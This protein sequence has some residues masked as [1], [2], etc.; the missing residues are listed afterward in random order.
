MADNPEPIEVSIIAKVQ[1]LLDGLGQ[2]TA[3]VKSATSEMTGSLKG[4]EQMVTNLKAP[5]I[6]LGAVLAGGAMFKS[7]ISA[8]VDWTMEINKLSKVLNTSVQDAS[9]WAVALHSLGVSNDTMEGTVARLQGRLASGGAAFERWG[10]ATKN[11]AGGALPMTQ[12]IENMATK[13]QGLG[14]DQEK[15][16]MLTELAGRGWLNLLPIMRMTGE[17]LKEAKEEAEQLHLVVGPDGVAKTREY[18]E[19]M[20]KLELITKSLQIQVG[21]ALMP[22]LTSLGAWLGGS[23]ASAVTAFGVAIK[24]I[25]T[26]LQSVWFALQ[27]I[28]TVIGAVVID[29]VE[30]F[31]GVGE[32]ITKALHGDFSGAAAVMKQSAQDSKDLWKA[33]AESIKL[34]W[35][36]LG[37]S[38][39]GTWDKQP[40]G[41]GKVMPDAKPTPG[42][43]GKEKKDDHGEAASLKEEQAWEK[44]YLKR[45]EA[46]VRLEI[47]TAKETE[48]GKSKVEKAGE[49]T[50][51]AGLKDW[52]QKQKAAALQQ[53]NIYRSLINNMTAGWDQGIHMMLHGQLTLT[54]GFKA[55]MGQMG[56]VLEKTLINMGLNWVKAMVLQAVMSKESH[57]TE[58]L[59]TARMAAGHAYDSTVK[60][61][62]VGPFLAPAAAGVAYAGVMAYAEGGWDNVPA[63]QMAMIHKNEMVLS[64]P[65]AEGMRQM[66][67]AGGDGGGGD[68]HL[69]LNGVTDATWWKHNQGNIMRTVGEAMRNGRNG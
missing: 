52:I 14:T 22:V 59:T 3:G 13:Y 19:S 51:E 45:R 11:A 24:V 34:D 48:E 42:K 64:A 60:I 40:V 62:Y 57:A 67:A 17:R 23:G 39:A 36:G 5:F 35:E 53:E 30:G 26:A 46:E 50:R 12:I 28:G 69:H 44:A 63:N 31:S 8:T 27:T 25:S 55:A 47:G 20:R 43:P 16:T 9:T 4:L 7:A 65:I 56:D 32:A 37:D 10:I 38:L 66:I 33:T 54:D 21:E 6:A 18:Q 2:A 61:P 41:K 49:K 1:G 58:I 15:N 29:L 68:I